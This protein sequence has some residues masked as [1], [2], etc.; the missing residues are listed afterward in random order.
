ADKNGATNIALRGLGKILDTQDPLSK[1]GVAV[2]LP[3]SFLDEAISVIDKLLKAKET[4]KSS[5]G[6]G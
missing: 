4:L 5:A 2:A 6:D 1:L 3:E